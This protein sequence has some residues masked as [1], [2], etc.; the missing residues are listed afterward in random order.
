MTLFISI[1]YGNVC[2]LILSNEQLAL[3]V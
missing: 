3:V 1:K 2:T